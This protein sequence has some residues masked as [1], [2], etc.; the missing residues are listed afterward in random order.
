MRCGR[1]CRGDRARAGRASTGCGARGSL[2]GPRLAARGCAAGCM[3]RILGGIWCERAG[4]GRVQ[5]EIP[6][7]SETLI[8]PSIGA[9]RPR[10]TEPCAVVIFGATGDLTRRKLMPAL[11]DLALNRLLPERFAVIGF[12]RSPG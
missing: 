6:A 1:C 9:A 10:G 5:S 8:L 3:G 7:M 2:L 11:Y 12:A 4:A